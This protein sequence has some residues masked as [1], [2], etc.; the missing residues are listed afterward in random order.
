MCCT[1]HQD[2]YSHR[3]HKPKTIWARHINDK[4]N[5][6]RDMMIQCHIKM[7]PIIQ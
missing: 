7:L 6:M 4:P 3:F 5:I 2:G 1:K